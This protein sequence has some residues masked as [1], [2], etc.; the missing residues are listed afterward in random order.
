[1]NNELIE[2]IR[3]LIPVYAQELLDTLHDNDL[4]CSRFYSCNAINKKVEDAL[5]PLFPDYHVHTYVYGE[6][7]RHAEPFKG[8]LNKLIPTPME[9]YV[10]AFIHQYANYFVKVTE[11][12]LSAR[13]AWL[14]YLA[15]GVLDCSECETY[16]K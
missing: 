4:A 2:N 16:T 3:K 8:E 15:T 5:I 12:R 13:K 6:L 11:A 1:M 9:W 10:D 14:S 7:Q